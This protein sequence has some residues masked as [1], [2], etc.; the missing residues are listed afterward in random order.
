MPE[1]PQGDTCLRQ[2]RG[3]VVAVLVHQVV[4]VALVLLAQLLHNLLYVVLQEVLAP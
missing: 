4:G 1:G 3:E 2:R